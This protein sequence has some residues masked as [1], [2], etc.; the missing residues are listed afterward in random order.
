MDHLKTGPWSLKD[1]DNIP[2]NNLNV[3]SC[4]HCGGGSTMGYKLA[5]FNVLGGVEIDPEMM[6]IYKANHN[7]KHSYLMSIQNF[8]KLNREDV[9]KELFNL[10]ILDGSPPCS[11]FSMA[12]NRDDGWQKYKMFREGQSVQVLDDLFF[13]FIETVKI[14]QPKVVIAENVKGLSLGKSKGYVKQI[15]AGFNSIGYDLQLF[16]LN[17]A[18]MGVPQRRERTFFIARKKSLNIKPLLLN[19]NENLISFIESC[20]DIKDEKG[21]DCQ[22]STL[23]KYWKKIRHG[24]AMS[25]AHEKGSLFGQIKINPLYPAPTITTMKYQLWHWE[26]PNLL[27]NKQ[28]IRLQTFPEDFNFINSQIKYI[29]GMSV[30]P[31][32]MQRI[33]NQVYLQWFKPKELN[34]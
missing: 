16:L 2:K 26:S 21:K 7:P 12:G 24:Q 18:F 19:F 25:K 28:I 20:H 31:F 13:E 6:V 34:A 33:A 5:G 30:P 8:N 17:S 22:G 14:L 32:M 1:I 9:P 10:D 15:A 4:F 11:S 27:S 29:V 3:F 23:V